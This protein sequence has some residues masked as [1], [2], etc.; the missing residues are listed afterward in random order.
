L[1]KPYSLRNSRDIQSVRQNGISYSNVWLVL[2]TARNELAINR[3]AVI[4][5]KSVGGAVQR[6]RC[7]RL[8]RARVNRYSDQLEQGFDILVIARKRLLD[9]TPTEIDQAVHGLLVKA[10]LI[11]KENHG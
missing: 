5:S 11:S 10:G 2:I 3:A 4:A 6:N 7:K 1:R 9:A 8:L